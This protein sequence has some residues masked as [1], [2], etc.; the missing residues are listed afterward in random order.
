MTDYKITLPNAVDEMLAKLSQ[1]M[2]CPKSLYIQQLVL[3]FIQDQEDLLEAEQQMEKIA[4]G[5]IQTIPLETI[6]K[7]YGLGH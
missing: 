3:D 5:E 6:M 7:Q 1:K 4:S 2:G